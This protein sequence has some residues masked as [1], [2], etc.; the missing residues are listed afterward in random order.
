MD[1]QL[2]QKDAIIRQMREYKR[3]KATLESQ[4]LEVEKRSKY[5]DEHLRT[6]D[7]WF[8]QVGRVLRLCLYDTC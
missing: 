7:T 2:Y 8:D 3:E 1:L 4:L 5:H 6:V